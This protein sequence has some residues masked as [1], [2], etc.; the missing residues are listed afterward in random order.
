V[1][2]WVVAQLY[3]AVTLVFSDINRNRRRGLK[4]WV[5]KN[6]KNTA[7]NRQKQHSIE[8]VLHIQNHNFSTSWTQK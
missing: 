6:T 4:R 2:L 5:V 7:S 1:I 3:K 8:P